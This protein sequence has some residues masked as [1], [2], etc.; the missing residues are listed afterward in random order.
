[1]LNVFKQKKI[2]S[3]AALVMVMGA[4]SYAGATENAQ[5][6]SDIDI[7][8]L[9]APNP[10]KYQIEDRSDPFV[11][12]ISKGSAQKE[13]QKDEIVEDDKVLTGMQLFEPGQLRVVAFISNNGI[14]QAMVEDVT[15][16]GYILDEGILIGRN[17]LISSI[18][19]DEVEVIDT[20]HTRAGRTIENKIFMRMD[21]EEQ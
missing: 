4:W 14:S 21:R 2:V 18:R 9:D 19:D 17:G 10:Y 3:A 8:W 16:R 13:T 1:M 15:G 6:G 11:P 20:A 7:S 5:D 12:F